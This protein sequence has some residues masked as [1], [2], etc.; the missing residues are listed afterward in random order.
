M[1]TAAYTLCAVLSLACAALLLRAWA[2]SRS[3]LLLWS[4]RTTDASAS[5][6]ST[7]RVAGG[8]GI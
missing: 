8:G 4:G 6:S 2:A 3:R 5:R 1:A 7:A